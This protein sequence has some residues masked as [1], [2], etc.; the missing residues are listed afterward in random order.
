MMQKPTIETVLVR[1]FDYKSGL[2][3]INRS[4]DEISQLK[5]LVK[6]ENWIP[7]C[8]TDKHVSFLLGLVTLKI[9]NQ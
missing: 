1:A 2:E 6:D 5:R 7:Q 3:R 8:V 9:I 4:E